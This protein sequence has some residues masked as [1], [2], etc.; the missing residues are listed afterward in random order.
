MT[1]ETRT[2]VDD[3]VRSLLGDDHLPE[4]PHARGCDVDDCDWCRWAVVTPEMTTLLDVGSD[5]RRL[6]RSDVLATVPGVVAA[7]QLFD[8]FDG[9]DIAGVDV[10]SARQMTALVRNDTSRHLDDLDRQVRDATRPG[11]PVDNRCR[12]T[13]G[14]IAAASLLSGT[15]SALVA[16]LPPPVRACLDEL[17]QSVSGGVQLSSV[18]PV[19]EHLHWRGMPELASQPEW[20]RRPN[21]GADHLVR[22]R[23]LS[24]SG[25][26][27]GSLEALV[28][29]SV[30]DR[31]TEMLLDVGTSLAAA[32]KPLVYRRPTTDRPFDSRLRKTLWRVL[33]IDWH[34]T[35]VDTGRAACWDTEV[36]SGVRS[37]MV[38]WVVDL[39]ARALRG[40]GF[41]SALFH[42]LPTI[43]TINEPESERSAAPLWISTAL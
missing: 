6:A 23:Q 4:C 26:Q 11:G 2:R 43:D 38:P 24:A 36:A 3:R 35:L 37:T 39:A 13:A 42:E 29:E 40:F 8:L 9:V 5:A 12:R 32:A 41:G 21:P 20:S 22:Q 25:V 1:T 17:A 30:L 28:L 14:A 19:I 15:N 27:T 33:P 18:L 31:Y 10:A 16:A 7:A 34:V